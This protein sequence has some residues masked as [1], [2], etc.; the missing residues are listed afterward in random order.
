MIKE[1]RQKW[2]RALKARK[3][4]AVKIEHAAAIDKAICLHR[5]DIVS[6][7]DFEP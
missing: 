3:R 5:A 4:R 7:D 1:I 2:L 6:D